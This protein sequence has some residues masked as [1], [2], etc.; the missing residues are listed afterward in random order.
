MNHAMSRGNTLSRLGIFCSRS[1][2]L[3]IALCFVAS[4]PVTPRA[5]AQDR[6]ATETFQ[7]AAQALR[8][9]NLDAA[10]QGFESVVK[11]SPQFAEAYLNLGLVREE[12]GRN[13]D[14]VASLQKA[15]ALKSRLRG[16]NLFLAIAEYRLNHSDQ[17][18]AALKKETSLYPSDPNAW[19][20]L[21]VVQ[22]A[23]ENPDE[24]VVA[25]DKAVILA[26][27]DVD[28]LYHRGRAHLLVSKR[29][30]EQMFQADPKSWRVHQVIAQADAEADKHKDAV[31]EYLA[32]IELVPKQPGLH[33]E[34]ATEYMK[35]G[36]FDEAEAA[37]QEELEIDPNNVLATYKLGT[38]EGEHGQGAKSKELIERALHMRPALKD[39]AYYLGRA[40]ME[41][42]DDAA[43]IDSFKQEIAAID[44]STEIVQQAWYQ[45]GIVYRR[46]RRIPEAQQ[47]LTTFQKL[48]DEETER[49]REALEKKRKAQ[50]LRGQDSAPKNP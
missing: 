21:G 8:Q 35:D 18:I 42:G 46:M 1:G 6:V 47:A 20:W 17:A 44:A 25:L 30:Y 31:A 37:L 49:Q 39:S 26:P 13:E 40:E 36:K 23:A 15:L 2:A 28:V 29:S 11:S 5:C 3:G 12:Q 38:L 43:A 22:L 7:H 24:A 34:L 32:A 4:C 16:A 10:A 19:M 45:L 9:G 50:A 48:K 14:A 41:L 27:N 33:E